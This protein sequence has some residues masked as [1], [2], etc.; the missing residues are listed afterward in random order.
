MSF[1]PG[2]GFD[3]KGFSIV[4]LMITLLI[5]SIIIGIVLMT[6]VVTQRKAE[7][8]SCK[9]NLRTLYNAINQYSA[10]NN[11]EYPASLDIL[12]EEKYLKDFDWKCPSGDYGSIS[13]DYRVH[14]NKVTGHTSCPRP[15]HNP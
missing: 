1:K 4:E 9:M 10:L 6:M 12:V 7:Q 2:S 15:D 3:E 14:Y 13:G 5:L 11:G 8:A